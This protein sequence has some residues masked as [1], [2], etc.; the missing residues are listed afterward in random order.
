MIKRFEIVWLDRAG[1]PGH[2][3]QS[4]IMPMKLLMVTN[5]QREIL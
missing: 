5:F 3:S 4:I 1:M 2:R